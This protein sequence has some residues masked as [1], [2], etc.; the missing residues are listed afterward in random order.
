M[1]EERIQ[2]VRRY[3]MLKIDKSD[4]RGKEFFEETIRQTHPGS[5]LSWC[6]EGETAERFTL[7]IS[8]PR[9]NV[10]LDATREAL[11]QAAD[12]PS[13]HP[14]LLRRIK[15]ELRVSELGRTRGCVREV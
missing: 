9:G 3:F 4:E 1:A 12:D 13:S 2:T 8:G 15:S 10:K 11:H 5:N 6:K 7:A 14:R